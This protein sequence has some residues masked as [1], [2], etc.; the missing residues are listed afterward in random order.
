LNGLFARALRDYWVRPE[1]TGG[2]PDPTPPY[3]RKGLFEVDGTAKP[4]AAVVER[5]FKST[6]PF[7]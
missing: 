3:S 2:N 5:E 4:A 6:P 1:R 7:K